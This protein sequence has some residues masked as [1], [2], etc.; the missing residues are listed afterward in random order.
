MGAQVDIQNA[1]LAGGVAVGTCSD[2]TIQPGGAMATGMVAGFVSVLGFR[3]LTPWLERNIGLH[4]SC[5]VHNLHGI[6]GL[7]A[8]IGGAISSS[9]A[10]TSLYGINVG[11]IFQAR[12]PSNA[13]EAALLGVLPG[14][15]R[16]ASLQAGYQIAALG[17]SLGFGILGGLFVG[18]ILRSNLFQ[19]L[20]NFFH[21]KDA[22]HVPEFYSIDGADSN[23][24]F[25]KLVNDM[26]TDAAEGN[27]HNHSLPPF[28]KSKQVVP[29]ESLQDKLSD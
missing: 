10:S 28:E 18:A 8:G 12:A 29:M 16:S 20:E 3:Y 13:T 4:D 19:R 26:N 14:Q 15:N 21:D 7:M 24:W 5:G 6:P 9:Y 27:E 2:L 22:W 11:I 25:R 23:T 17:T 1:T